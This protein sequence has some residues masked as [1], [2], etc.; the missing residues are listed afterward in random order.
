MPQF[1]VI[2]RF[3]RN[4]DMLV[5]IYSVYATVKAESIMV[6][7]ERA[8]IVI[9]HVFDNPTNVKYEVRED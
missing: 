9:E 2:A 8:T 6:A 3:K 5:D 4:P 7:I 1:T